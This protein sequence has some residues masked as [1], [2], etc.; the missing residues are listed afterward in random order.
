MKKSYNKLLFFMLLLPFSMFAQTV[1]KGVVLD[2]KTNQP[3]SG[4]NVVVQGAGK[5][6]STD[7]EGNFQLKN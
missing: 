4:V 5:S 6:T 2:S 7:F 3:F 1:L